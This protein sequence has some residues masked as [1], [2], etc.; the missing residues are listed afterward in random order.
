MGEAASGIYTA[1][2][3]SFCLTA[4][5]MGPRIGSDHEQGDPVGILPPSAANS[6]QEF[7]EL[8]SSC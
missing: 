5:E 6:A 3:W 2:K 8:I 7:N 4:G 1:H